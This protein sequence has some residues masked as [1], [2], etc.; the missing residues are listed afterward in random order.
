MARRLCL[1]LH[2]GR[3]LVGRRTRADGLE[4]VDLDTNGDDLS[5]ALDDKIILNG[6]VKHAL[7][8]VVVALEYEIQ[9][10]QKVA[11]LSN[12]TAAP[13]TFKVTLGLGAYVPFDG[14]R[15]RLSTGR[16]AQNVS[17][18]EIELNADDTCREVSRSFV[19][20]PSST[21]E[22]QS[23]MSATGTGD[24]DTQTLQQYASGKVVRFCLARSTVPPPRRAKIED[25]RTRRPIERP[26]IVQMSNPSSM[27]RTWAR[28]AMMV[29]HRK[30]MKVSRPCPRRRRRR[31]P[32][33]RSARS[34]RQRRRTRT[35]RLLCPGASSRARL[36][37]PSSGPSA[38]TRRRRRSTEGTRRTTRTTCLA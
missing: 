34:P 19:F 11:V 22:G 24:F 18:C 37:D 17:Y 23:A 25:C 4:R 1:G 9:P 14:R 26:M 33:R 38:A 13:K 8:A 20:P 2:N 7:Y 10:A 12:K 32:S 3:A 15:L 31:R 16:D 6:Y 29:C 28:R 35:T 30:K 27:T 21:G 36:V 5:A